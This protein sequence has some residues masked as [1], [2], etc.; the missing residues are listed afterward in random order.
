MEE[1][2]I[3]EFG[4]YVV[5]PGHGVGRV[6]NVEEKSWEDNLNPFIVSKL[7]AME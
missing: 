7:S 1:S 4:E 3:F 5:C 2:Q 6:I